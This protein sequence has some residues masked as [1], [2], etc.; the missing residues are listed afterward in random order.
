MPRENGTGAKDGEEERMLN[1]AGVEPS[2]AEPTEK[3]KLAQ[4]EVEVKFIPSQNGDAR[5]DMELESQ[6]N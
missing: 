2:G 4:K 6:V 3:D 5:I 1:G